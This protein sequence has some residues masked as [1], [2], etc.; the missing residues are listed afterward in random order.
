MR[1]VP[2]HRDRPQGESAVT[3][4]IRVP[5]DIQYIQYINGRSVYS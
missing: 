5:K 1:N 2:L 4:L 3:L